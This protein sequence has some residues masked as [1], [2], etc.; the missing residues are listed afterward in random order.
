MTP[1]ALRVLC[2]SNLMPGFDNKGAHLP[3]CHLVMALARVVCRGRE[4]RRRQCHQVAWCTARSQM[5][6]LHSMCTG[7]IRWV[8]LPANHRNN[9]GTSTCMHAASLYVAS[10]TQ[11]MRTRHKSNA[12][13]AQLHLHSQQQSEHHHTRCDRSLDSPG[14]AVW[15][16]VCADAAV[17]APALRWDSRPRCGAVGS[18]PAHWSSGELNAC[19]RTCRCSMWTIDHATLCCNTLHSPGLWTSPA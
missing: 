10:R 4:K 6:H 5:V 19:S 1:D 13:R 14:S 7:Q 18:L 15:W 8:C 11:H 17:C 2:M 12:W 16:Y 3:Q 9:L